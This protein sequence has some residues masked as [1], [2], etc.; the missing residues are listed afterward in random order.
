MFTLEEATVTFGS[1]RAVGPISLEI[2]RGSTTVLLGPSGCGKST[3]L[4]ALIGLVEV[5]SGSARFEGSEVRG[6]A[7]EAVRRRTGF[8]IQEGG[9][10]PH[11]T[12]RANLALQMRDQG[13]DG[14]RIASRIEELM[15]L[16]RL[17]RDVLDRHP[18]QISGGQRQ[19]VALARALMPDPDVL[20]LDEPLGALDPITRRELQDELAELFTSLGKTVVLVTHDLAEARHFA[21]GPIVLMREGRIEQQG[22]YDALVSEPASA[23]VRAFVNAEVRA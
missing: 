17:D 12:V 6:G 20:L 8:V 2:E 9:L 1:V 7:V 23:F 10:F 13:I 3:L 22:G 18:G 19:R 14:S 11:L 16:T 15:G 5:A 4:R 21:T